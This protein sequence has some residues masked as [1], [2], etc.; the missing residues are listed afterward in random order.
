MLGKKLLIP[1][2]LIATFARGEEPRPHDSHP[3]HGPGFSVRHWQGGHW[4]HGPYFDRTGWWWIVGPDWYFYDDP[5]YPYPPFEVQPIYTAQVNGPLPEPITPL[6]TQPP[7]SSSTATSGPRA[8]FYSCEK[9]KSNYPTVTVCEAGWVAV[10]V[11]PPPSATSTSS[12]TEISFNYLYYC[13]NLHAYYPHVN[14]CPKPWIAVLNNNPVLYQL[15]PYYPEP[16]TSELAVIKRPK[17]VTLEFMGR[18]GVFSFNYDQA[19]TEHWTAGLGISYWE[20]HS[21]WRNYYGYIT[22]VPVYANY[23][24]NTHPDRGYLTAGFDWISVSQSGTPAE[25]DVFAHDGIA[26]VLGAGYESRTNSGFMFRIAIYVI[27]GHYAEIIP[28]MALGYAF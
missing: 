24:F 13:S 26:G 25:H 5:V 16:A 1:L 27:A 18:S 14:E 4:H 6:P 19:F 7:S 9:S 28:G 8:Y 22:V 17:L 10:P 2:L 23:Y 11:P 12:Q 20:S 21:W 15:V 3:W